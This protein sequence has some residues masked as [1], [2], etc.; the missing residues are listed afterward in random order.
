MARANQRGRFR[1]VSS[2]PRA[3]LNRLRRFLK[4]GKTCGVRPWAGPGFAYDLTRPL[5]GVGLPTGQQVP[6][7]RAGLLMAVMLM[8]QALLERGDLSGDR[9]EGVAHGAPCR[10]A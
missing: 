10:R 9:R 5:A 4:D 3:G 7:P 8:L 1:T 2:A 6:H